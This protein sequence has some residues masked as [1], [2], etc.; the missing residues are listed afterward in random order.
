LSLSPGQLQ[1]QKLLQEQIYQMLRTAI[2]S[3]EL[4]PGQRLLET[5]LAKKLQVS[6]TPVREAI[7]LLQHDELATIDQ[8][9]TM[10][11][12]TVSMTVAAELYDCRIALEEMSI[13]GAC[14]NITDSQL[15]EL[16]NMV[17][18]AEV[19]MGSSRSQLT[20]YRLLDLDY[21]FH[22]LLAR[23]SGNSCLIS[24]LDGVFERMLLLRI[25]TMKSNPDVLEIR[26]EHRRIYEA[27]A[28]RLPELAVAA[29]KEHLTSS[30]ER[31]LR[32]VQQIQQATA[33][34]Q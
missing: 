26:L 1:R 3:G 25:Q 18:Q 21:R 13:R 32:E 8:N 7:R 31:V 5:Q 19:L 12:A 2:L 14:Q 27:V 9:G 23:S 30:K 11:V 6:R 28:K 29:I 22:R 24:I 10:R 20:D 33:A 16:E 15:Q 17:R 34:A 4:V